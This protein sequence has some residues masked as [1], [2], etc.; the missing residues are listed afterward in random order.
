[1]ISDLALWK[2][3][4]SNKKI[5]YSST[6]WRTNSC[7]YDWKV[8]LLQWSISYT[9]W[10]PIHGLEGVKY[11][12]KFK[13]VLKIAVGLYTPDSKR[14]MVLQKQHLLLWCALFGVHFFANIST[15]ATSLAIWLLHATFSLMP[16][17]FLTWRHLYL[18]MQILVKSKIVTG[19]WEF[20]FDDLWS[21]F[22]YLFGAA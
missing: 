17:W 14:L 13:F 11:T 1:M 7:I 21:S 4:L 10:G 19:I 3:S 2:A 9:K 5:L 8:S 22:I 15:A 6:F 20:H 12:C 16:Q 18:E